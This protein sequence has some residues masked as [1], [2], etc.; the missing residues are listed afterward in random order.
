MLNAEVFY[1]S[2]TGRSKGSGLVEFKTRQEAEVALDRFN[3]TTFAGRELHV[4]EDRE[5]YAVGGA[6]H[7]TRLYVGNLAWQVKR[8][9][10][11]VE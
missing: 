3:K 8:T 1:E 6:A 7:G 5:D 2:D 9:L 4:K 10:F 11:Y